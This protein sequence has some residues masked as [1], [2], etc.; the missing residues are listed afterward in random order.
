MLGCSRLEGHESATDGRSITLI[1]PWAWEEDASI[2]A[3]GTELLTIIKRMV[4]D[5]GIRYAHLINPKLVLD[6][7]R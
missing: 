5:A 6:L 3:T 4:A 1:D 7:S 2:K